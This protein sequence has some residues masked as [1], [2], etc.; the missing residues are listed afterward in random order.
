[1]KS[2]HQVAVRHHIKSVL[3]VSDPLHSE[4]IKTEASDL[5]FHPVYTSP[6]S[7]LDLNRSRGHESRRAAPRNRVTTAV[8]A[9]ETL[10][11]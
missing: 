2:V 6:D 1:M 9:A 3:L 8:Q 11:V 4:R 7:Y 10:S 5:G